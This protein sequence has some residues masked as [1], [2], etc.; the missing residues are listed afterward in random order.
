MRCDNITVFVAFT[1]I[2]YYY[3][4]GNIDEVWFEIVG[5]IQ[6]AF[7]FMNSIILG[8]GIWR[9]NKVFKNQP[10]LA[11]N[12]KYMLM[13]AI[14]VSIV[15]TIRILWIFLFANNTDFNTAYFVTS[16]LYIIFLFINNCLLAFIMI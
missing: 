10:N 5:W 2:L 12:E 14:I 1:P 7:C 3:M 11:A 9:I 4:V 6:P 13:N 16:N 15:A 8:I